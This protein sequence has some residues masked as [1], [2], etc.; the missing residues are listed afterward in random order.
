M[1]TKSSEDLLRE[2]GLDFTKM[3]VANNAANVIQ[4]EP[5]HVGKPATAPPP[6]FPGVDKFDVFADLDP[7]QSKHFAG[8]AATFQVSM[9]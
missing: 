7:L 3:S 8:P 2:Y 1:F 9:I 4:F 5:P 6:A